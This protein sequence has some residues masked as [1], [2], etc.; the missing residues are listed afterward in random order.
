M[1]LFFDDS[2]SLHSPAQK[3]LSYW[4][5]LP[6]IPTLQQ[7]VEQ[8]LSWCLRK[9]ITIAKTYQ[10]RRQTF[11]SWLSRYARDR[12]K[13]K[14]KKK[15]KR[16][17]KKVFFFF[18]CLQ[19]WYTTWKKKKAIALTLVQYLGQGRLKTTTKKNKKKLVLKCTA[20]SVILITDLF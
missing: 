12:W 19:T 8:H 13:K 9:I 10:Q 6:L 11:L 20:S 17:R 2:H 3:P 5:G 1:F 4:W 16:R 14:K 7:Q 15:I 18:F